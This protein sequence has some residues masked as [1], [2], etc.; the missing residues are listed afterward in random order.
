MRTALCLPMT[1][2]LITTA[3]AGPKSAKQILPFRGT[4]EGSELSIPTGPPPP[5][6]TGFDIHGGGSGNGTHLGAFT[7]DWFFEGTIFPGTGG[8]AEGP[9]SR[10]F[11]AAN[12]DQ[13]WS[14]GFGMGTTPDADG[15]IHVVESHTIVGGTGRF[16]GARGSF[17]LERL[18]QLDFANPAD[19]SPTWGSFDGTIILKGAPFKGRIDGKED[20]NF[21]VGDPSGIDLVILGN[22][23]GRATQ[24][25]SF[26]ATW[27]GDITFGPDPDAL[28][29]LART[30]VAANGDELWSEGWGAGTPPDADPNFNQYVVEDHVIIG[31]TGRFEGA[32]GSFT[33]ERVVYDVRPGIDLVSEGSFHGVLL[34]A[35][36]PNHRADRSH[37]KF[38]SHRNG[39]ILRG[40]TR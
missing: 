3:V 17:T 38:R 11:V 2:L 4:V 9:G 6:N 20:F 36:R 26:S 14:E 34:R 5:N 35:N 13:L 33:V 22:G 12:G 1:A 29:P 28:Q 19:P 18:V 25:G 31:G 30:F 21:Q 15:L 32:T 39:R 8:A 40:P 7:V 27:I 37:A 10:T 23:G 24:L 16:E